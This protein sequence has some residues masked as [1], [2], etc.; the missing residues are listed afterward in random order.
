MENRPV[1]QIGGDLLIE[2]SKAR[3]RGG[4][5]SGVIFVPGE[6]LLAASKK[7]NKM[8]TCKRPEQG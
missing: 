7:R 5:L 6:C 2:G 4:A 1:R 8:A 3:R